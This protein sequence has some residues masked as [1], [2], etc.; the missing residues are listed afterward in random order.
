[1][2][3]IIRIGTRGSKLAM[4]QTNMVIDRMKEYF[5]E[6]EIEVVQMVTKGDQI[7]DKQ[8][9]EF[10]GKAVFVDEFENALLEN[11]ID[12]AVHSSKDMPMELSKGLVVAGV[13]PQ[14]D[15]RDVLVYDKQREN[16]LTQSIKWRIGTG[17]LRRK[18]QVQELYPYAEIMPIRGNVNTRIQKMKDGEYDAIVLA[19]AG[20]KRMGYLQDESLGFHF[21]STEEVIP[22]AG[23]GIVAMETRAEGSAYE[24]VQRISHEKSFFRLGVERSMLKEM[25]A[26]CHEP[27]GIFLEDNGEDKVLHIM[28]AR[29]GQVVKTSGKLS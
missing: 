28:N 2:A 7:L 8:L 5:P 22:A 18:V 23:Q 15:P 27:I 12:I 14:E 17:S 20:L 3:D 9:H 19:A 4:I 26:G 21:F 13:L 16:E 29:D 25:D 1:M 6:M 24:I 10:G 11:R